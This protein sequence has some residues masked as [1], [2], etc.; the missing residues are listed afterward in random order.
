[1]YKPD[2]QPWANPNILPKLHYPAIYVR[3]F[4]SHQSIWGYS[5]SDQNGVDLL[6]WAS[7]HY[8]HFTNDPKQWGTFPQWDI[9]NHPLQ[10]IRS[11]LKNF[12][13]SQYRLI[14]ATAG[15]TIPIV[16]TNKK[17]PL[18]LSES[19]LAQIYTVHWPLH[20]L[21]LTQHLYWG[22]SHAVNKSHLQSCHWV[23]SK[24]LL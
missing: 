16:S 22:S 20:Y 10:A 11:V 2:T 4:N 1:M 8:L 3:N 15:I 17:P 18:K 6:D 9:D 14:L 21:Y 23:N 5:K 19:K 12:P 7:L 24:R 13:C